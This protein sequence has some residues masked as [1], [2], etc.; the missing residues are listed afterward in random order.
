[1]PRPG[2]STV[3]AVVDAPSV[4]QLAILHLGMALGVVS[5]L[6]VVL[7]FALRPAS[8]GFQRG[9]APTLAVVHA[10]VAVAGWSG[11]A[12]LPRL[13]LRPARTASL[14][15]QHAATDPP[16]ERQLAEIAWQRVRVTH[17][18]RLAIVEGVAAL[19]LTSLLFG[20]LSG[21]LAE[22]PALWAQL[23]SPAVF[24]VFVA[25][26]V[27]VRERLQRAVQRALD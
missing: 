22:Q 18:A 9:L 13:L 17:V 4:R 5:F 20:A 10:A 16:D 25:L 21:E 7:V 19:G 12:L 24:V 27:P 3:D 1:M 11:A 2:R 14:A 6:V 23:V 15:R 26:T 8:A